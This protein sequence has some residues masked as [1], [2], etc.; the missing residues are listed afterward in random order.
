MFSLVL[1]LCEALMI[2]GIVIIIRITTDSQNP[3]H[4]KVN[5][6]HHFIF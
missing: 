6:N 5:W 3:S 4:I 2:S 1:S